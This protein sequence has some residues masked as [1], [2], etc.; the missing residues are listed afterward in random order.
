MGRFEEPGAGEM[1]TGIVAVG[2]VGC[3]RLQRLL[4]LA[5]LDADDRDVAFSQ[6]V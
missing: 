4:G 2:L 6:A 3:Q 1:A 5:A